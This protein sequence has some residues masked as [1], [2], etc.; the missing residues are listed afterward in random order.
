MN[1]I[2]E[3]ECSETQDDIFVLNDDAIFLILS[4]LSWMDINNV[5]LLSRRFYG[6][7]HKNYYRLRRREARGLSIRYDKNNE[8]HLFH[9]KI[10]L[11]SLEGRISCL[12]QFCYYKKI[13]KIQSGEGLSSFIKVFDT[14]D[15]RYLKIHVA[16]GIVVFDILIS[17]ERDKIMRSSNFSATTNNT[18]VWRLEMYPGG[19]F[20]TSGDY[21]SLKDYLKSQSGTLLPND[22]LT[23]FCEICAVYDTVDINGFSPSISVKSLPS[24]LVND[25]ASMLDT[26][27]FYDCTIKVGEN[28]IRAHKSIVSS[29]SLVFRAMFTSKLS[30]SQTS[31]VEIND[32]RYEVVKEMIN[33]IYKDSTSNLEEMGIEIL[34]IADKYNLEGLKA[35]TEQS[36]CHT[37]NVGTIFEYFKISEVYGARRLRGYCLEFLRSNAPDI[38]NTEYWSTFV[39][40]CPELVANLCR[41]LFQQYRNYNYK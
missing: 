14:R 6:I 11:N 28:N 10:T 30:E 17:G 38:L 3:R 37:L 2:I 21:L 20:K 25:I 13:I 41:N 26:C 4:K 19:E 35:M 36:L 39:R 9:I 34:A 29:C 7:V 32:F 5:K 8:N 16:D 27:Q 31:I 12:G 33:Y 24:T 1:A 22:K 40:E 18:I 15:P 23:V